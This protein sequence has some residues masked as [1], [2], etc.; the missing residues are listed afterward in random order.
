MCPLINVKK[1]RFTTKAPGCRDTSPA[2]V[3]LQ[4]EYLLND[5][6]TIVRVR[7]DVIEKQTRRTS[8]PP[9]GSSMSSSY[10]LHGA[11]IFVVPNWLPRTF[12]HALPPG[13]LKAMRESLRT[14][15]RIEGHPSG[16]YWKIDGSE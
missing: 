1:F 3:I 12:D 4:T 14:R 5:L 2:Q 15:G 7:G 9:R 6:R 8:S 11:S 16:R 13:R 10:L